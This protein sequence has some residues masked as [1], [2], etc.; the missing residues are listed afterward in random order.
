MDFTKQEKVLMKMIA[1]IF[2]QR[3]MK[4]EGNDRRFN[5]RQLFYVYNKF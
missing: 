2:Y 4:S 1:L 3:D 5:T